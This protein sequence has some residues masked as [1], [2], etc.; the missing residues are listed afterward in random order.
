MADGD[1]TGILVNK[2]NDS[3]D[4]DVKATLLNRENDSK[5]C[6]GTAPSI[7]TAP[8]VDMGNQTRKLLMV[9]EKKDMEAGAKTASAVDNEVADGVGEEEV[10]V[11]SENAQQ[12]AESEI[13]TT[14]DKNVTKEKKDTDASDPSQTEQVGASIHKKIKL[15]LLQILL[16]QK[17]MT[18]WQ[19]VRVQEHQSTRK[20]IPKMVM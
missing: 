1:G 4:G 9:Q 20:M 17:R 6:V 19:M 14:V 2:E 8:S 12:K 15:K 10:M 5:E 3:K 11:A 13:A 7:S 16:V 18:I